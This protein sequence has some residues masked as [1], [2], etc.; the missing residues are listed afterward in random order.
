LLW[1]RLI[2]RWREL[3]LGVTNEQVQSVAH[4]YL[5]EGLAGDKTSEAVLGEITEEIQNDKEWEKFDFE[6]SQEYEDERVEAVASN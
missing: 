4:K 5:V 3:G 2:C 6:E 1:L